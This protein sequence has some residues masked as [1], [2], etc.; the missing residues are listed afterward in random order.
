MPSKSL[1]FRGN[2]FSGGKHSKVRLS[3][4]ATS[5]AVDEKISMFVIGNA[6]SW[7]VTSLADID[8]K[9]KCGRMGHFLTNGCTSSIISLK[10]KEERL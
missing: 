4:M 1:Q 3:G 9:R 6:S 7:L 8:L 5:N 2:R 10:C